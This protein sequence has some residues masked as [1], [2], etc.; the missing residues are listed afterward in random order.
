[1]S[2]TTLLFGS[3]ICGL[4]K[5]ELINKWLPQQ[6]RLHSTKLYREKQEEGVAALQGMHIRVATKREWKKEKEKKRRGEKVALLISEV[7]WKTKKKAEYILSFL[8]H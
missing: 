1:M 3:C 8:F 6:L 5:V 2:G 7:A 4:I